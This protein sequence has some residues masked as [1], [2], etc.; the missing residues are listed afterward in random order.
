MNKQIIL[1]ICL[2]VLASLWM[3]R[4]HQSIAV[5]KNFAG[6]VPF[7]TSSGLFGVFNQN[8]GKIYVYDNNLSQCLYEGQMEELGKPVTKIHSQKP[9]PVTTYDSSTLK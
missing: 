1:T 6:V 3:L 4:P 8:N 5:G 2:A 7:V 9:S